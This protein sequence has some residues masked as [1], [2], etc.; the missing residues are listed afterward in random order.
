MLRR[1]A[2]R[3]RPCCP[4][5]PVYSAR[6]ARRS[7]APSLRLFLLLVLLLAGLVVEH[8]APLV[9][10]VGDARIDGRRDDGLAR[11]AGARLRILL[12]L[13]VLLALRR[14]VVRRRIGGDGRRVGR[15]LDDRLRWRR[16]RRRR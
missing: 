10:V 4:R 8:L 2:R 6:R 9:I 11:R 7:R 16:C 15:R 3:P 14:L 1:T 13:L 5:A 12:V